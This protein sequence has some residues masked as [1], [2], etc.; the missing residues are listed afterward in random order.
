MTY[1]DKVSLKYFSELFCRLLKSLP[2]R[3]CW[4]LWDLSPVIFLLILIT[5]F[6]MSTWWIFFLSLSVLIIVPR[7]SWEWIHFGQFFS[8]RIFLFL[9][10]FNSRT[11]IYSVPLFALIL[12]GRELEHDGWGFG[13]LILWTHLESC[14]KNRTATEWISPLKDCSEKRGKIYI[15]IWLWVS[16]PKIR[17]FQ[18]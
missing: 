7:L 1:R 5:I 13:N 18:I 4:I 6:I 14:N 16:C 12:L 9:S 3:S 8:F 17:L 10:F 11:W 2:S 15:F